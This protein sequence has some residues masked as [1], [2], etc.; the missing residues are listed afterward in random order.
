VNIAERAVSD[1][2]EASGA[3]EPWEAPYVVSSS[4]ADT[5]KVI[6]PPEDDTLGFS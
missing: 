5:K 6:D 1:S 3:R 4:A 2:E